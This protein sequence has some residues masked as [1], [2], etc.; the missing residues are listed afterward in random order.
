M[1]PLV[2]AVKTFAKPFELPAPWN[3]TSIMLSPGMYAG[4]IRPHD[5]ELLR[6]VG[7]GSIHFCGNGQHLIEAM[8]EVPD[9]LGLDFGDSKM[10]EIP[11]FYGLCRDRRVALTGI[12]QSRE[13]LAGGASVRSYPTGISF[14]Y[15]AESFEDARDVVTRYREFG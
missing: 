9:L 14:L 10:M 11:A 15:F 1:P 12:E 2:A 8:I 3:D 7:K 13:D 6:A 4:L 5:A